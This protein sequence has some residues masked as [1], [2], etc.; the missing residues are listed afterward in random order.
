MQACSH[1]RGCENT[2]TAALRGIWKTCACGVV[3]SAGGSQVS[4]V[5]DNLPEVLTSHRMQHPSNTGESNTLL[6]YLILVPLCAWNIKLWR[7]VLQGE[8][9][10]LI[11]CHC[12]PHGPDSLWSPSQDMCHLLCSLFSWGLVLSLLVLNWAFLL[13]LAIVELASLCDYQACAEI[14]SCDTH[15]CW[16]NWQMLLL[17]C[18]P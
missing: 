3:F 11:G 8:L 9:I 10:P 15:E 1:I 7:P 18:S 17:S 5:S 13:S 4:H 12:D 14:P 6:S 16:G 2:L